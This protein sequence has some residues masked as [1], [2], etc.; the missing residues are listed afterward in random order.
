ML[1]DQPPKRWIPPTVGGSSRP[2]GDPS[3]A[4]FTRRKRRPLTRNGPPGPSLVRLAS[5]LLAPFGTVRA[6]ASLLGLGD[7]YQSLGDRPRRLAIQAARPLRSLFSSL[8]P[9]IAGSN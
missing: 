3:I 8:I 1:S 4:S 7:F 2:Q 9:L 6:S 5:P